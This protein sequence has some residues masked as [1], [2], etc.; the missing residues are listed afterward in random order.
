MILK[1]ELKPRHVRLSQKLFTFHSTIADKRSYHS[2]QRLAVSGGRLA[3][4]WPPI[5]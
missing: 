1:T 3:P 2:L 4:E 5:W